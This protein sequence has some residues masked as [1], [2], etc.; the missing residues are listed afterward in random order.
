[1]QSQEIIVNSS[2]RLEIK[3]KE[4]SHLDAVVVNGFYSQPKETFTGS[5]TTITGEE[6]VKVSPTNLISGLAALTP[7]MV[8]VE[9]NAAGSNPNAIPSLL[10]RGA[11]TLITNESEEGVNNP[12]TVS[13]THLTLPTTPYV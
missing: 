13:Y 5:A 2:T 12:L 7:G 10:I 3:L 8:V 1:M 6:I 4:D 9:N 11:N